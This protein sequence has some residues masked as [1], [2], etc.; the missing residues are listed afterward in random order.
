MR[1]I[2]YIVIS[3]LLLLG[4][5]K[6]NINAPTNN[7]YE[8]V[9]P[10][11]IDVGNS[12]IS[13]GYE[14][15][16]MAYV[17]KSEDHGNDF[18]YVFYPSSGDFQMIELPSL[19][20]YKENVRVDSDSYV[21]SIMNQQLVHAKLN[22][23]VF[24]NETLSTFI[25]AS[26]YIEEYTMMNLHQVL[27]NSGYK[28]T[29]GFY[30]K[31]FDGYSLA[32]NVKG[33]AINLYKDGIFYRYL[34]DSTGMK[35]GLE[36]GYCSY[37]VYEHLEDNCIDEDVSEITSYYD[38][39]VHPEL[40][41]LGLHLYDLDLYYDAMLNLKWGEVRVFEPNRFPTFDKS[42]F[43]PDPESESYFNL[44]LSY[45]NAVFTDYSISVNYG[46]TRGIF[47]YEDKTF[48]LVNSSAVYNFGSD[49]GFCDG[50]SY[51]FK[52][53]RGTCSDAKVAEIVRVKNAMY[54]VL[55]RA[56]LNANEL[57]LC[58]NVTGK[59]DKTIA[60]EVGG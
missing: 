47:Y 43:T 23:S 33:K 2:V 32:F 39:L 7:E 6:E 37:N 60:T 44:M 51:N 42:I 11:T 35:Y 26:S 5:S 14:P 45:R 1:K 55:D 59:Y 58:F 9:Q 19:R 41:R 29:N 54:G 27:L 4:C 52:N 31:H 8:E 10:T 30:E 22:P 56:N 15:F 50:C 57:N 21:N 48:T 18:L 24:G 36:E 20:V 28:E 53:G 16:D 12:L 3:C 13:I 38:S 46:G 17:R 40:V 25:D 49:V 34:S